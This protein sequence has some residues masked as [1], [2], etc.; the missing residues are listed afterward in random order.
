MSVATPKLDAILADAGEKR[1]FE[2]F[3]RKRLC[4]ENLDFLRDVNEYKSL[5]SESSR[6]KRAAQ[7]YNDY[8]ADD[9]QTAI[10]IPHT[11]RDPLKAQLNLGKIDLYDRALNDVRR[12]LEHDCASG[13]VIACVGA[14]LLIPKITFRLIESI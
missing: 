4:G 2:A 11:T 10:N 5:S 9:A 3:V 1:R 6:K 13:F 14:S 8:I 12:L 7:I